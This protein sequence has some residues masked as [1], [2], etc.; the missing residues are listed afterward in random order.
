MAT[1][2]YKGGTVEQSAQRQS[3]EKTTRGFREVMTD[4]LGFDPLEDHL[5]G[6]GA[7]E[8]GAESSY[9]AESNLAAAAEALPPD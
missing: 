9:L 8:M 1:T 7:E 5:L 3:V 4:Y 2:T 6:E